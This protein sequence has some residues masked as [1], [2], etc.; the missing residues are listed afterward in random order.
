M[1]EY[2]K[3]WWLLIAVI[4][5]CF[6][7]LGWFGREVYRAAPPIP[8]QVIAADGSTLFTEKDILDG[9]TAWQVGRAHV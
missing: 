4:G 1:G 3:L 2:R 6:S 7:L 9:Q 8:Q 5:I